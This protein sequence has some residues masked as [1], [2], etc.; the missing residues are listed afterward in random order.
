MSADGRRVYL[1][2]TAFYPASGGQPYDLG[3]LGDQRVVEVIDDED[4][5]IAH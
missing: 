3:W 2:R 1:D 4:G 5:R